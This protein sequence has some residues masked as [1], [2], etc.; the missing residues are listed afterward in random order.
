MTT[1]G[2]IC[3]GL[4][5]LWA[6]FIFSNSL[7]IGTESTGMSS[8]I[9]DTLIGLLSKVGIK[10]LDVDMVTTIVRKAEIGRAHV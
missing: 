10:S 7:K 9:V 8:G 6:V 5:T 1:K 2:K 4:A 3:A